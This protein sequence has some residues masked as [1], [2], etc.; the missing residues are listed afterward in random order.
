MRTNES[1]SVRESRVA[2]PVTPCTAPISTHRG[3]IADQMRRAVGIAEQAFAESMN[4]SAPVFP[5]YARNGS[6]HVESEST[7]G[8]Q[9]LPSSTPLKAAW[10]CAVGSPSPRR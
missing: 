9:R 4:T 8:S 3:A 1:H 10:C 2:R 5:S 6:A 7:R